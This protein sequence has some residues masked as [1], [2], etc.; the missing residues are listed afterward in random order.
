MPKH[1]SRL[2]STLIIAMITGASGVGPALAGSAAGG[3]TE[4]TQVL[5]NG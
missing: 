2:H 4:F 5:N 3:A 1:F